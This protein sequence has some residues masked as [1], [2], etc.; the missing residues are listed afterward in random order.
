MSKDRDELIEI[1]SNELGLTPYEAKAYVAVLFDGPLSPK[2]VNQKSGIPRP[3]TYDVLTSLVGKGLLMEQ[4]G[5]PSKYLAV[6]PGM[7]LKKLMEDEEQKIVRQ[8]RQRWDAVESLVSSLSGPYSSARDAITPEDAVWVTRKD[9]AMVAKYTEAIKNVKKEFAIATAL[10]TPPDKEILAA[11]KHVLKQ[12]KKSRVIRPI[13]AS[14]SKEDLEEY[15][16]LIKLGDDIR[17]LDYEGLTFAVFDRKEIILWL[18]PHPSTLT[19]W[20]RLPELAEVLMER[21]ESLWEESSPALP[22]LETLLKKA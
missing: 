19:I 12:K 1:L 5:K 14:W 15:K 9:R 11:V 6:D 22:L 10:S 7:G 20:I 21:F 13:K 17:H 18:P 8:V 2:G 16:E 4:P 3:R